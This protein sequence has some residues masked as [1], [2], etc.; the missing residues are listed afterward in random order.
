MW[1]WVLAH[2]VVVGHIISS[3]TVDIDHACMLLRMR[4]T[5]LL[6]CLSICMILRD[7]D[8]RS[9][10]ATPLPGLARV[11]LVHCTD[12]VLS[13]CSGA[14]KCSPR[15]RNTT[16]WNFIDNIYTKLA[17]LFKTDHCFC[18]IYH[19]LHWIWNMMMH[20]QLP[21]YKLQIYKLQHYYSIVRCLGEDSNFIAIGFGTAFWPSSICPSYVK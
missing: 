7:K 11:C 12:I 14:P 13:Y 9:R 21:N 18:V 19:L 1:R 16:E 5:K 8:S 3:C 2:Q 10:K 6:H 20:G 17:T 15:V 4:G